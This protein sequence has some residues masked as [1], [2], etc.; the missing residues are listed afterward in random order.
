M[1]DEAWAFLEQ[2]AV[3]ALECGREQL[4]EACISRLAEKFPD[5]PRVQV[6]QG[7]LLE[8]KLQWSIARDFY[9]KILADEETCIPIRKRLISLHLNHSPIPNTKISKYRDSS[10]DFKKGVALLIEHLDAVFN[11]PEG[12]LELVEVYE[13]IASYNQSLSALSNLILLQPYN[14]LFLLRNAETMYTAQDY[15]GAWKVF[16]RVIE[17]SGSWKEKWIDSEEEKTGTDFASGGGLGRR[18]AFGVKLTARKLL[19]SPNPAVERKVVQDVDILMTKLLMDIYSEDWAPGNKG[20]RGVASENDRQ[21]IR[22]WLEAT[23]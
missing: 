7:C 9:E 22:K 13:R 5:S 2:T 8:H 14:T 4:A 23:K 21:V 20:G 11:D 6:L 17:I 12:W 16:L 19:A 15:P 10:L 1:G 3:A 18:A